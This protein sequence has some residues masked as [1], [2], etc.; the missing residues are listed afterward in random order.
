MDVE[1]CGVLSALGAS[2]WI[3]ICDVCRQLNWCVLFTVVFV[4]M[5]VS[6]ACPANGLSCRQCNRI[7]GTTGS[8]NVVVCRKAV[9]SCAG[10]SAMSKLLL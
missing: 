10:I 7:T 9:Q 5:V 4:Q 6:F 3:R 2:C 1:F 8:C